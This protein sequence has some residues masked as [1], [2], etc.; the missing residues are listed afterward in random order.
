MGSEAIKIHKCS[1]IGSNLDS[2][3]ECDH[4]KDYWEKICTKDPKSVECNKAEDIF[5]NAL[6]RNFTPNY[7]ENYWVYNKARE[8]DCSDL[9][10][11]ANEDCFFK[12]KTM[13]DACREKIFAEECT[14]G[15]SLFKQGEEKDFEPDYTDDYWRTQ[16][17]LKESDCA[18]REEEFADCQQ[19]FDSWQE[20]CWTDLNSD[21]CLEAEKRFTN[22]LTDGFERRNFIWNYAE[23]IKEQINA[24][25][26]KDKLSPEADSRKRDAGWQKRKMEIQRERYNKGA[27]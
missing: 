16:N 22:G 5:I 4:K 24:Y 13:V 23:K 3:K 11:D 7:N 17:L 25:F 26:M 10:G 21:E 15:I 8:Y 9:S 20:K 14:N 19:K 18:G 1:T 2:Y 27:K 12:G 6:K